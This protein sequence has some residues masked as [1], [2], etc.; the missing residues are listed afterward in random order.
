MTRDRTID[1]TRERILAWLMPALLLV[2]GGAVPARAQTPDFKKHLAEMSWKNTLFVLV[3]ELEYAPGSP[4]RPMSV[5]ARLWYGGAVQRVWMRTEAGQT[6]SLGRN[7][8]EGE[9]EVMYG[10]LV[11]PYWD[12][13]IGARVDRGWGG[14]SDGRTH[15]SVGL[16]GLAPYRFEIEP[17]LFVSERG[18]VS[19][20]LKAEFQVLFTH[21][22]IAEPALEVNAA[23]QEVPR[24]GVRSGL[25]DYGF[26]LRLRYEIRREF[27]PYVGWV[28]TQRIGDDRFGEPGAPTGSRF[29]TG[30]RFWY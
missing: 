29:V 10:R 22:L 12:A 19:A 27:S 14:E 9:L 23:L 2:C 7:H 28:R 24:F 18:H 8:G 6:T 5:D 17:T 16:I 3:D 26:G 21:R 13:V 30:V 15:L 1:R 4:G 20:R 25:N 11:H